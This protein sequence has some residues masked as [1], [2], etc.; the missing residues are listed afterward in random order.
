MSKKSALLLLVSLLITAALSAAPRDRE[1]P[2][3]PDRGVNPIERIIENLKH[4]IVHVLDDFVT[5][6]KP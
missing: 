3:D 2:R 6:P 5:V 1:T 4:R